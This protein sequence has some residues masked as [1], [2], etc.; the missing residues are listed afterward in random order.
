MPRDPQVM[1]YVGIRKFVVA[2]DERSGTEVWR[3]QLKG[4]DFVTVSWDGES[5]LAANNG[6]VYRLDPQS[7]AIIWRNQLEGL[8]R[9]LVTLASSR[10]GRADV[11]TDITAA[12][13]KRNNDAAAAAAAAG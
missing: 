11:G 5:L 3:A 12:K 10:V 13:K 2:L 9:G 6:E 1:I 8:G 7:G 4:G